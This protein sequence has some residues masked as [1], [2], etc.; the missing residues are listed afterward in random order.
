VDRGALERVVQH[1]DRVQLLLL[2]VVGVGVV[3]S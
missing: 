1:G 2:V 3:L